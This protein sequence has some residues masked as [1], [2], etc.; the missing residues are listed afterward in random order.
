MQVD[1]PTTHPTDEAVDDCHLDEICSTAV[2]IAQVAF[3]VTI[4]V[5]SLVFS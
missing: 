3:P 4:I 5:Y 2:R 1:R